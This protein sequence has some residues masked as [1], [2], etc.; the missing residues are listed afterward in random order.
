ML[1]EAKYEANVPSEIEIPHWRIHDLRR[2]VAS[3]MAR[4]G[5]PLPVIEKVLSHTSGSFGGIAGVYQRHE[6]AEEKRNALEAWGKHVMVL[7]EGENNA[8]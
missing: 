5:V 6:F 3:G 7:V 4:L 1:E 8:D 2:T